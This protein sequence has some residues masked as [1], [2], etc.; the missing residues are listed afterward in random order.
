MIIAM[1]IYL[2]SPSPS[3]KTNGNNNS[4]ITSPSSRLSPGT[5]ATNQCQN[6][7]SVLKDR[8]KTIIKYITIDVF[9]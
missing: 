7:D 2:W 4:N 8:D 9:E 6:S 1:N 3:G 5:F